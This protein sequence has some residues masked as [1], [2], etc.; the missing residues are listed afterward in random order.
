M[1]ALIT[2]DG[3]QA[4]G[5]KTCV[6]ML[7]SYLNRNFWR[8]QYYGLKNAFNSF[9]GLHHTEFSRL[10]FWAGIVE[11]LNASEWERKDFVVLKEFWT[12]FIHNSFNTDTFELIELLFCKNSKAIIPD[13]SFFIDLPFR[14]SQI[15]FMKREA[16]HRGLASAIEEVDVSGLNENQF[17]KSE[18]FYKE[19]LE[20]LQDN[21]PNFYVL[22]GTLSKEEMFDDILYTLKERGIIDAAHA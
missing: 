17:D 7:G 5:K 20:F 16:V 19:A 10:Y 15:R 8:T 1:K 18:R 4:S 13:A 11:S 3:L 12:P 6:D 22:D 9:P 21:I 2:F 14:E